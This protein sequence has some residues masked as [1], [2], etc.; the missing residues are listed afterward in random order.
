MPTWL[1]VLL[2]A[3]GLIGAGYAALHYRSAAA[4]TKAAAEEPSVPAVSKPSDAAKSHPY[5]KYIEVAGF[6]VSESPNQKLDVRMVVINHSGAD[7]PKFKLEVEL[8]ASNSK[9]DTPPISSF[10]AEVPGIAAQSSRDVRASAATQ[11]RAYE[12]PDW[13]F[14][15]ADFNFVSQ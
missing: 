9:P 8:R 14:L 15:R 3:G 5:A 4:S 6:R 2:V 11:L 1:V 12:F 10:T 13:Q 7:L